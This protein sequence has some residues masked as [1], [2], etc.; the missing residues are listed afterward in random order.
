MRASDLLDR[1]SPRA[2]PFRVGEWL[3][4]GHADHRFELTP[5]VL[6]G[7]EPDA[8][9]RLGG[10]GTTS[11]RFQQSYEKRLLVRFRHVLNEQGLRLPAGTDPL[12]S[13]G[14]VQELGPLL[15][16]TEEWP[17]ASWLPLV[18][19]AQHHGVP[20]RLLDWSRSPYIAAYFAAKGAIAV[21]S[22]PARSSSSQL[23]VWAFRPP[24]V[25]MVNQSQLRVFYPSYGDNP[26]LAAQRGAFTLWMSRPD[27][28]DGPVD[29]RPLEVRLAAELQDKSA[30]GYE[31]THLTLP[32]REAPAL[33]R[34]LK[35]L[36][37]HAAS[38][39]PGY[40]GVAESL[41]EE[42]F[43]DQLEVER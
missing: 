7:G 3:F 32:A 1:L 41:R 13:F 33:L 38:M 21:D 14:L 10:P 26:N 17:S 27:E 34:E 31:I 19:L 16:G 9:I 8:G 11:E 23:S 25:P 42:W 18:A 4:R 28:L 30:V 5:R 12:M 20:T 6:R 39:F 43:L 36:G 2:E 29:R 35:L 37:V 24:V 15:A 22:R 40:G